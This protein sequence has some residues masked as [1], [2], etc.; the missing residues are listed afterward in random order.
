MISST[1]LQALERKVR[2]LM[3]E[4]RFMDAIAEIRT[5]A[6]LHGEDRNQLARKVAELALE[7]GHV[8]P[9]PQRS[10]MELQD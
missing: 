9:I 8:Q 10:A 6:F 4:G 7:L 1:L 3:S 5:A 2:S